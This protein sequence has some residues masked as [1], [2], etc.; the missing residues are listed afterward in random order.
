MALRAQLERRAAVLA[1]IRRFFAE[2]GVLEVTTDLIHPYAP[3]D[4]FGRCLRA[5]D[6]QGAVQGWLL[7]SP[8]LAMKPLLAAGAGDIFQIC[9]AFRAGESGPRHRPEFTLVD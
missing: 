8:E 6:E 4:P 2:R 3:S 5:I 7:P 9:K 1:A